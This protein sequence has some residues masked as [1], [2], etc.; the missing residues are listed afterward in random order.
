MLR[1]IWRSPFVKNAWSHKLSYFFFHF[2]TSFTGLGF[3]YNGLLI[4]LRVIPP[5]LHGMG[6]AGGG[7]GGGGGEG[8]GGGKVLFCKGIYPKRK[9]SAP[10]GI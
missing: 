3:P 4:H 2:S 9:E 10:S 8:G 7:G 6:K 5:I 1:Q